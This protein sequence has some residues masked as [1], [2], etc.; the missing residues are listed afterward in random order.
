ML[1]TL[2]PIA[3]SFITDMDR[4]SNQ[5]ATAQRQLSSG[6]K[7]SQVSDAPDSISILL[8]ARADLA[9]TQQIQ[10]NLGS[11]KTETDGGEQALSSAV[12]LLEQ[13]E[14]LGAQGATGTATADSR[15]TLANQV[16]SIMQEMVGLSQTSISGRYIFSGD[17]DQTP[18]YTID[19]TQNPPISAYAGGPADRQIQHP[20]G[21]RFTVAENAQQIFDASNPTQNVWTSLTALYNALQ[22]GDQTAVTAAMPNMAS[23]LTYLNDQLAFYGNVQDQVANATDFASNQALQLQTHISDLQDADITQSITELQQAQVQETAAIEAEANVPR[24]TLFDYLK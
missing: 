4:I 3:Q 12:S 1:S 6:L 22:S 13:A 18:P 16:G 14:T 23:S 9:S 24:T 5:M 17:A 8:Q 2:N 15:Q 21:S 10:T 20:N 19:L 7:V 11:V